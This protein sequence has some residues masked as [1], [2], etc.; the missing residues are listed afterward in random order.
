MQV[1]VQ[2]TWTVLN[3]PK[4]NLRFLKITIYMLTECSSQTFV[5][6]PFAWWRHFTTMTRES[7]RVLLSCALIRAFVIQ[8]SLGL[9]NLHVKEKNE[10]NSGRSSKMT[11]APSYKW[12]I[13][14]HDCSCLKC[15]IT[16]RQDDKLVHRWELVCDQSFRSTHMTL[17]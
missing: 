14:L 12:P 6:R 7:F 5:N 1:Y 2:C 11:V 3:A 16:F 8:T 10:K 13:I 4:Y 15:S 9:L 17:T